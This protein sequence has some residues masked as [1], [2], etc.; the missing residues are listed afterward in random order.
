MEWLTRIPRLVRDPF[1]A[2]QH[3]GRTAHGSAPVPVV[4][5]FG[6]TVTPHKEDGPRKV[7]KLR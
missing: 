2:V 7:L 4:I 5:A 1:P 6:V 3:P